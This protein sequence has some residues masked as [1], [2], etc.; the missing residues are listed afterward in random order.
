M[1][2]TIHEINVNVNGADAGTSTTKQQQTIQDVKSRGA[3]QPLARR[4][5]APQAQQA[6]RIRAPGVVGRASRLTSQIGAGNYGFAGASAIAIGL[7]AFNIGSEWAAQSANLRG[8]TTQGRQIAETQRNVNFAGSLIATTLIGAQ[9]GGPIG[10]AVAFAT[11][12][13]TR[14]FELAKETRQY[15]RDQLISRYQSQYYS[16]RLIANLSERRF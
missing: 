15:V 14:A 9:V 10:A 3:Q 1:P 13:A 5:Q 7:T 16:D 11:V 4:A 8:A 12:M 6:Q 2:N